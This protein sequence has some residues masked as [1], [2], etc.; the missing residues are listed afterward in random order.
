M[1]VEHGKAIASLVLGICSCVSCFFNV[2]AIVGVI[3]G[4]LG[5]VFSKKAS[6]A[7][8]TENIN[9]AGFVL[10]IIGLCLSGIVFVVTVF[11]IGA[12][13]TTEVML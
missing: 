3:L 4:I 9:K 6:N 8:N 5:I 11:V 12:L 7:G 10:S 2:G 13:A 1:V